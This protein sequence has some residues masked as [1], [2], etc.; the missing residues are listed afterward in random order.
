MLQ[1]PVGRQLLSGKEPGKRVKQMPAK[2][3]IKSAIRLALRFAGI[4]HVIV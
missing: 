3:K 4:F 2:R 1:L